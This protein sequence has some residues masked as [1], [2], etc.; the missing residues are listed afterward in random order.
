[1]EV[2]L[3]LPRVSLKIKKT[4]AIPTQFLWLWRTFTRM[5]LNELLADIDRLKSEL[6]ALRPFDSI[7][8]QK[9]LQ[10]FRID[11]NFH[12]NSIEG[13]SLTYGETKTFLLHGLTAQGKPL[14]DHLEIKGHN[15]AILELQDIVKNHVPLTETSIRQLHQLILPEPYENPAITRD[16]I[17][18]RRRIT[19]GRY[20]VEPNHVQTTTGEVFYF[21]TPEET[22][23]LM[24]ELMTWYHGAI[25]NN[26]VHPLTIAAEFHYRLVMIHPF[27]DGNG[28]IARLLMNLVLMMKGFPPV[29]IKVQDKRN[30]LQALQKADG[31]DFSEFTKYVGAQLVQSLKISIDAASGT[32]VEEAF[33]KYSY[34]SD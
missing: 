16:G 4:L 2:N 11:W 26:E 27:D 22:P 14:V 24:N 10:K 5:N 20:K 7:V 29:I 32:N 25:E 23:A 18:T 33:V 6:E 12:S 30:Y 3:L 13:N 15:E 21:A 28:R 8:E 1:M 17:P 34:G 9:V 31:G 19:P